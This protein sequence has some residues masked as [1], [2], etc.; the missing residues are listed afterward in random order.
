MK[1][2][3]I[4]MSGGVDSSLAA[5]LILESGADAVG[6]TLSLFKSDGA[7]ISDAARVCGE[8]GIKHSILSFHDDFKKFVTDVF[9]SEYLNGRTPNPCV[10]CNRYIKFGKMLEAAEKLGCDGL[11]TG[12]YAAVE[13]Q[14]GRYLL[15]RAADEKK[16]QS[17]MLYT[18]NQHQLSRAVFPLG[19]LT[20]AEVRHLAEQRGISVS[21][22]KD[23][24]DICFVPDGDY[25]GFI[26]RTLGKKA[27]AGDFCDRNGNVLGRHSGIIR[28]TEGQ[29]KGLGIALGKPMFVL[30]KKAETNRVIL[31]SE[32]ALFYRRVEVR[33]INYI[34]FDS[35]SSD[36]RVKAKLRYRHTAQSAVLHPTENGAVLEFDLPQRAPT[37]GQSAVFYDGDIVI[38]GGIISL[39]E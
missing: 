30:E 27:A 2:V 4:G 28:Y 32:D 10:V 8:L 12:H 5:S 23:S 29:R 36:M 34:P 26:E 6:A 37:C 20:K 3:L 31:G 38:G 1:K 25:V 7:D 14:G 24:Q 9:I 19:G 13:K 18:L 21:H 15:K 22:K 16:D 35:L 39:I 17:Y 33:D 11:A